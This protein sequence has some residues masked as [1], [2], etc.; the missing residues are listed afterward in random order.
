MLGAC[1]LMEDPDG[2]PGFWS[3]L[4]QPW[5][6]QLSGE[7]K[8]HLENLSLSPSNPAFPKGLLRAGT[9][10]QCLPIVPVILL[11]LSHWKRGT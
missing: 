6:L 5:L 10:P 9:V 2:I 3:W 11:R 8:Q 1:L 7:V 4:A